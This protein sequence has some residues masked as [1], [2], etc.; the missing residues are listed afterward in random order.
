VRAHALGELEVVPLSC[1]SLPSLLDT[2]RRAVAMV[3]RPAWSM[4]RMRGLSISSVS[5]SGKWRIVSP[6]SWTRIAPFAPKRWTMN[7]DIV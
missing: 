4:A 1:T 2:A 3:T 5:V 6:S 7:C